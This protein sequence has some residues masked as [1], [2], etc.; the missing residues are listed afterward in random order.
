MKSQKL[1]KQHN[2]VSGIFLAVLLMVFSAC[3]SGKLDRNGWQITV[4]TQKNSITASHDSLG[5]VLQNVQLALKDHSGNLIPLTGWSVKVNGDNLAIKT[6]KPEKIDWTFSAVPDLLK[7]HCSAGNGVLTGTAPASEERIVAREKSQDNGVMYT[8]LGLVSARNIH[9]LF[10]RKTDILVRFPDNSELTRDE[11]DAQIMIVSFPV[12]KETG[13]TLVPEYYNNVVGLAKYQKT[14]FQPVYKPIPKR[15][16]SAPTGWSSWYCYYMTANE[17]DMVKETD[18]LAKLL[19]PYGLEYVQLDA[20][21]TRGEDAN[22]LDW[23]KEAFPKGGKWLFRYILDKG[24][25]PGLWLNAYGANYSK[26]AMA[27]R[28]PENFFL[29]DKNGKLSGA[30][31]TA[32]RTVVRLDYTNPAVMQKHLIP[33]FDTLVNSWGLKYLKAGGWGTWMNYYE[34][35]RRQAYDSTRDSRTVYRDVLMTIREVM[36][37]DNYLLGC[38]MHEVGCGFGLFDGS[39][40]GGDD[41]AQWYPSKEG[42]MSMQNYFKSLFGANY[43]NGIC[44][45]SDPDDVQLRPPLTMDEAKT[46][47]TSIALSGQAYIIS[48]FMAEPPPKGR[49]KSKIHQE[50][51]NALPPDR[52]ELYRETMPA[53]PVHAIDLY[54]YRCEP[55]VK[56]QPASF[57][58]ALDMKVNAVTGAYDVVAVYNWADQPGTKTVDLIQ[59]FGLYP[60]KKYIVFDFWAKQLLGIY[61]DTLML[62]IPVHGVRALIIRKLTNQPQIVA[63]SRHISGVYS[64]KNLSWDD[65]KKELSGISATIPGVDYTL[66]VYIPENISFSKASSNAEVLSQKVNGKLLQ[67]TLKGQK[68]PVDW[69]LA[70]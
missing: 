60:G 65:G 39:R 15:F 67:V 50:I 31:C 33:M 2:I 53:M 55:V 56:P 35:N 52:L 19:K 46:I 6:S 30:C 13:I 23:N 5:I 11:R 64:I 25:K 27:D 44:W 47:V 9:S 43:L 66:Y 54:P 14:K 57:P 45:W 17:D 10:D 32:D 26:P 1:F 62:D 69:T 42:R 70:F 4:D 18:A 68:N 59:D 37:D 3:S 40:T 63:V 34:K 22:Y 20:C 51:A 29:R 28:Y 16:A 12:K 41:L 24:L 8:A 21:Y 48:D 38:A 36:G 61:S 7:V 49:F 58:N